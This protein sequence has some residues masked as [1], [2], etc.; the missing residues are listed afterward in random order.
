VLRQRIGVSRL[1]ISDDLEMQAVSSRWTI[2]DAALQAIAAGCDA[3]LVCW[4]DDQQER[5]IE[6]LVRETERSRRSVLA[7]GGAGRMRAAR[8]RATA[9]PLD[10]EGIA[11]VVGEPSRAPSLRRWHAGSHDDA[12]ATG[13]RRDARPLSRRP[14]TGAANM[15]EL[16]WSSALEL[17]R[18]VR[19]RRVSS[20]DLVLTCLERIDAVNP[21]LT[22]FVEVLRDRALAEARA[23]DARLRKGGGQPAPFLGVPI[24]IKDL[25]LRAARSRASVRGPSR[26]SSRRSTTPS[27]A[28]CAAPDSSSSARPRRASSGRFPSPSRTFTR[29]RATPGT[30]MS[31]PAAR[32]AAR[33]RRS[34]RG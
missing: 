29:P 10:D 2:E 13:D 14:A 15:S 20:E 5:A 3:L 12:A 31:R 27:W 1:L 24:G 18:R 8:G 4:S 9:R 21:R 28:A 19:E 23:A 30:S 7:R 33:E 25:N 11:R 26:G 22:A 32:A 34:R 16:L 6:A 17:A